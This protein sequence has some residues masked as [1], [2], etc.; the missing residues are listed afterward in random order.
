MLVEHG[1]FVNNTTSTNSTPLRAACFDGHLPIVQY[2]IAHGADVE[3][4]NRH[5]KILPKSKIDNENFLVFILFQ[6]TRL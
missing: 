6:V 4:A 3:K 5:G 2:L 1:A